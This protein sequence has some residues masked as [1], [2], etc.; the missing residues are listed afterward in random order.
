M[1]VKQDLTKPPIQ[2]QRNIIAT[3]KKQIVIKRMA[4]TQQATINTDK[5]QV[6][7]EQTAQLP[8]VSMDRK[9]VATRLTAI[10]QILTINTATKH[11]LTKPTS[12]AKPP[13][14][15]NTA[16]K[17]RVINSYSNTTLFK[18]NSFFAVSRLTWNEQVLS[19]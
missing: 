15:T 17:S 14:M 4:I 6:H 16:E 9:P 12:M 7:I 11:E 8:Q 2:P 5:R 10:Q 19:M 3:V 13:T 18:L 1:A